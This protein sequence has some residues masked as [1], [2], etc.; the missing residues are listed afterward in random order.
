MRE[1]YQ[2][3]KGPGVPDTNRLGFPFREGVILETDRSRFPFREG[4]T[5]N[6]QVRFSLQGGV[7]PDT[8]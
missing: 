6:I 8:D 1:G 7:I 5:R 2:T 4:D 3:Q